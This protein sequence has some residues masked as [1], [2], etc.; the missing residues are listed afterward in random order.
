VYNLYT[1]ALCFFFILF[2]V[3]YIYKRRI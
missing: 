3:Y 1:I 2:L